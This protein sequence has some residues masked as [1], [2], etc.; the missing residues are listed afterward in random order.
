MRDYGRWRTH[1]GLCGSVRVFCL[2]NEMAGAEISNGRGLPRRPES[3]DRTQRRPNRPVRA[4]SKQIGLMDLICMCLH[5]RS[6][7]VGLDKKQHIV[8]LTHPFSSPPTA[9][10]VYPRSYYLVDRPSCSLGKGLCPPL[11]PHL[12]HSPPC[13]MSKKSQAHRAL[14]LRSQNPNSQ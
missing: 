4:E 3:G 10:Q 6:F 12:P 7:S 9:I 11:R 14:L 2:L 1:S 8:R 13:P 5:I